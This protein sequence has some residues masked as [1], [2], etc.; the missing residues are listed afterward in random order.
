[1]KMIN[2]LERISIKCFLVCN[3]LKMDPQIHGGE[4]IDDLYQ[5]L[6]DWFYF[7]PNPHNGLDRIMEFTFLYYNNPAGME[8][9]LSGKGKKWAISFVEERGKYMDSPASTQIVEKW[10]SD[11]NP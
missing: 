2:R 11:P 9:I 4:R 3:L 6:N 1:M 10:L 8:F 5:F 7:L